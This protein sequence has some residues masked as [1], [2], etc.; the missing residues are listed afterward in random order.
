MNQTL[1]EILGILKNKGKRQALFC[2]GA[3][4][5]VEETDKPI[6]QLVKTYS[7]LIM[8]SLR[9]KIQEDGR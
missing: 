1:F 7:T 6:S 9:R 4:I 3:H 8:I 2:H 5:S